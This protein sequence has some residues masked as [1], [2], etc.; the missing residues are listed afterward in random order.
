MGQA[1]ARPGCEPCKVEPGESWS[2]MRAAHAGD[3][4]GII[5][6]GGGEAFC[7]AC[8]VFIYETC[9]Q[10]VGCP[11]PAEDDPL[12]FPT[13]DRRASYRLSCEI[14][15]AAS[16]ANAQD[17]QQHL[18]YHRPPPS[19]D[20]LGGQRAAAKEASEYFAARQTTFGSQAAA[21]PS[22]SFSVTRGDGLAGAALAPRSVMSTS[23][24]WSAGS[25]GALSLR[26]SPNSKSMTPPSST[27]AWQ[28][29]IPR[30]QTVLATH[31]QG[32]SVQPT[33]SRCNAT[34]RAKSLARRVRRRAGRV[35]THLELAW[36]WS[37]HCHDNLQV[38]RLSPLTDRSVLPKRLPLGTDLPLPGRPPHLHRRRISERP[39]ELTSPAAPQQRT[40]DRRPAVPARILRTTS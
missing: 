16:I 3:A 31:G 27:R 30:S 12:E 26:R 13:C 22:M 20:F 36:F 29:A 19:K 21:R 15:C 9:T 17:E 32:S 5:A 18:P 11:V 25:S 4:I 24:S 39:D 1:L 35:A 2:S 34:N 14:G 7:V 40:L 38:A 8:P 10:R 37:Q 6:S 23:P 33:P 28:P